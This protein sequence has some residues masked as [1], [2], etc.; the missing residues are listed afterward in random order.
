MPVFPEG[1]A[2]VKK[3]VPSPFE[4]GAGRRCRARRGG[5]AVIMLQAGVTS[6]D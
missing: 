5:I 4:F 2:S 1:V 3:L 6:E